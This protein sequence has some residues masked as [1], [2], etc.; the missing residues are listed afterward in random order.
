MRQ[1]GIPGEVTVS[2]VVGVDGQVHDPKVLEATHPD[3]VTPAL[4]SIMQW[5]FASGIKG[6]KAV[7]T[8]IVAPVVFSVNDP[9]WF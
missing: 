3:F 8:R 2:F 5:R 6:G 1:A 7:N 4:E 9:N